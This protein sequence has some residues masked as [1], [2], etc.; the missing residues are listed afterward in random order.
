MAGTRCS[1]PR[2]H[3]G[4]AHLRKDGRWYDDWCGVTM[5]RQARVAT[6]AALAFVLVAGLAGCG[7]NGNR[8][9]EPGGS[10]KG[11]GKPGVSP[12]GTPRYNAGDGPGAAGIGL[13][14]GATGPA[15]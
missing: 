1:E 15:A 3:C 7:G 11:G 10:A 6:V 13:Q 9:V 5:R 12:P 2:A 8:F 14:G 4:R